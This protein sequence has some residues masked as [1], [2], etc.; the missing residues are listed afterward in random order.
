MQTASARYVDQPVFR[1]GLVTI[2]LFRCAPRSP[3]FRDSGPPESF[4]FVFPRTA[5]EIEHEGQR[6]FL[7][8]TRVATV[9]NRGQRYQRRPVDP[10]GDACEWFGVDPALLADAVASIDSRGG[11]E[12]R[13]PP[14]GWVSC[15]PWVYLRQ[16]NLFNR[17]RSGPAP[18]ALGVEEEV[19]LLLRALLTGGAERLA[20][21]RPESLALVE[22]ARRLLAESLAEPRTLSGVAAQLGYS[23]FHVCHTFR[24]LTG[25]SLHGY[26][27]DLRLREALNRISAAPRTD[28][29][30]LAQELG[31]SSHSHFTARFRR[32]FGV[33]PSTARNAVPSPYTPSPALEPR[34]SE[35]PSQ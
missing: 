21:P 29:S 5:V 32:H 23:P 14:R 10:R 31:F 7:A 26:R 13:M 6:P 19:V 20:E 2:G 27:T 11:N 15:P 30:D 28:L 34:I 3:H 25:A 8:D 16:R 22:A 17:L 24:K 35:R 33:P 18:D 4:L 1:S 9:Y 12:P